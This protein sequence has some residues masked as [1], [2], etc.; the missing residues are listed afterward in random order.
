M[1]HVIGERGVLVFDISFSSVLEGNTRD[2]RLSRLSEGDSIHLDSLQVTFASYKVNMLSR[3]SE[4]PPATSDNVFRYGTFEVDKIA[5]SLFESTSE[6]TF[7]VTLQSDPQFTLELHKNAISE[8][9]SLRT[10]MAFDGIDPSTG[11]YAFSYTG[12]TMHIRR[13]V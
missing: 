8:G 9:K 7:G 3:E 10:G 4:F 2:V 1:G 5:Q 12:L 11:K 6:S 13:N